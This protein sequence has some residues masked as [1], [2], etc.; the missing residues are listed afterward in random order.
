MDIEASL[1]GLAKAPT[2]IATDFINAIFK[3]ATA[4]IESKYPEGYFQLLKK[5]YVVTVPAVWSDKAQDATLRVGP[6]V[7]LH[8]LDI[9]FGLDS[10][11]RSFKL[12]VGIQQQAARNAG[13][14][15]VKLV[16]EPEA[17]ALFTLHHMGDK[18]LQVGDAFVVCDA[19][20]GTVDL[21]SYE[22]K[23]LKPFALK[24]LVAAK[25]T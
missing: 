2:T 22:I 3:H 9:A 18:G 4:K 24:E 13:L 23:S 19:G 20:G 14:A 1:K 5:Q 12:T 8:K 6:A 21:I 11:R 15:P 7:L 17:A 16:K 25:G 10:P